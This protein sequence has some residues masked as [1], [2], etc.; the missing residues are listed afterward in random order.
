M[1]RKAGKGVSF[2]RTRWLVCNGVA[3]A[4]L[5]ALTLVACLE[6]PPPPGVELVQQPSPSATPTS[7]STP[8]PEWPPTWTPTPTFTP[9]P[10]FTPT[11]T[12]TFT[13]VP[14]RRVRPSG[15][16]TGSGC[17]PGKSKGPLQIDYEFQGAWCPGG[18]RNYVAN[19]TI[20]ASGGDGCYTY[21]RDIDLIG[22]PVRGTAEYQVQWAECS[23]A[24]GTFFVESGDGQRAAALFWVRP[25]SCCK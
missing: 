12:P 23:G 10:T 2:G 18:G 22:G 25:P 19:F 3:I 1:S 16:V 20:S 14:A 17:R 9:W 6:P 7:T 24:P 4:V 5:L 13:P 11:P 15:S 21:Y 8:E